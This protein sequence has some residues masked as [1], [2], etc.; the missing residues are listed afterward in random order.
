M[1][2]NVN[3]PAASVVVT[4]DRGD[5][6][7]HNLSLVLDILVSGGAR[8][9][10][11]LVRDTGL[12]KATISSIVT[13]LIDRGLVAEHDSA[14]TGAMGRP[15][16]NVGPS[17]DHVA[18][19]AL[20]IAVDRLAACVVDLTGA[21]R[22][23]HAIEGD[24]SDRVA[25]DV[26]RDM[27]RVT[28]QALA[29]ARRL[30]LTCVEA[31]LAVPGLVDPGDGTLF[32]AP[33][34]HW[35]DVAGV[36]PAARIGLP[37]HL[38]VRTDNEAN[39]VALAELRNGVGRSATNF[40]VLS[41]GV[42]LGAGVVIDGRLVRGSHGFAGEIGHVVVDPDGAR[43]ACGARGC[44]EVVIRSATGARALDRTAAA[45]STALRSVVHLLDPQIVVL[46][47]NL[48]AHGPSLAMAIAT[49]LKADTL[50]ARWHPCEVAVSS[51]GPDA[52]LR[53]AAADAL[54]RVV[55]D[56]TRIPSL[57]T[58]TEQDSA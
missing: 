58:I 36:A 3:R 10:A 20:E 34:L 37:K 15:G 4:M 21:V 49:Q 33:N 56:P 1:R 8:S 43:C 48:A 9:R 24:Q 6:R 47:G 23:Q 14:G 27:R 5:I 16:T 19:L 44:L 11:D 25:N 52:A 39:L 7:R 45:I 41:G 42:G 26:L 28:K 12:T 55:D 46:S 17:P 40:V 31:T 54:N 51:L 32:V 38:R 29:D 50:G 18:V 53:G 57:S 2:T 13:D 22:A 35:L 30:G